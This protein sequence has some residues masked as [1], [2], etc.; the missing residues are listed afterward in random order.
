MYNLGGNQA[1]QLKNLFKRVKTFETMFY[2]A[3]CAEKAIERIH[4]VRIAYALFAKLVYYRDLI[5]RRRI[6]TTG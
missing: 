5:N 4:T 6:L 1:S 2:N 3:K